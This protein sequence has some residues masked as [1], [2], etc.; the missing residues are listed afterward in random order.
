VGRAGFVDLVS[1]QII[2]QIPVGGAPRI[3]RRGPP[4]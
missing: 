3:Y 2:G 1:F 4:S